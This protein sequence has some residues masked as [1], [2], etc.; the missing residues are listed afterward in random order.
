MLGDIGE[1]HCVGAAPLGSL[2]AG[3]FLS[4]FVFPEGQVASELRL[5][6]SWVLLARGRSREGLRVIGEAGLDMLA[7]CIHAFGLLPRKRLAVEF[8]ATS[9]ESLACC[10]ID[11]AGCFL[12]FEDIIFAPR[13][14]ESGPLVTSC[15]GDF[16]FLLCY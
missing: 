13:P 9:P 4:S 12:I 5:G 2:K 8:D 7:F 1:R 15:R 16:L 6:S 11:D 10:L 3:I 14:Q